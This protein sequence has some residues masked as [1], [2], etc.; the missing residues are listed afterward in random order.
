MF[1]RG[2]RRMRLVSLFALVSVLLLL[3]RCASQQQEGDSHQEEEAAGGQEEDLKAVRAQYEGLSEEQADALNEV[4]EQYH[5][6]LGEF[7][8]ENREPVVKQIFSHQEE[9]GRAHV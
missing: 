3:T 9:I 8:K 6:A 5:L 7:V 1:V 4:I 2:V